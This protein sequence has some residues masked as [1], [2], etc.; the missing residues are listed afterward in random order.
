LSA[1][2]RLERFR[3]GCVAPT[4]SGRNATS[5]MMHLPRAVCFNKLDSRNK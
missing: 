1:F 3:A 4:R 5:A 2:C